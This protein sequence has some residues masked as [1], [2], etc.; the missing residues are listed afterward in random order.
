M[1]LRT[2]RDAAGTAWEAWE[3]MPTNRLTQ[4]GAVTAEL[5]LGWLTLRSPG[6][7][8]RVCPTPEGWQ[9]MTDDELRAMLASAEPERAD[10]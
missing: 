5:S 9:R 4:H 7:R 8:R 3:I 6:E 1:S 2:F 10:G